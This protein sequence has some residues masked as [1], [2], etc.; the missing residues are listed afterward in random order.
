M[1][2]LIESGKLLKK[3]DQLP[4]N[5]SGEMSATPNITPKLGSFHQMANF[6]TLP[7][8]PIIA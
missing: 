8:S 4:E 7:Q 1:A 6:E 2:A 5:L 3:T